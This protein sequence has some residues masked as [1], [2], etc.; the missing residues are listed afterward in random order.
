MFGRPSTCCL[1]VC[2]QKGDAKDE[3]RLR[4]EFLQ[5]RDAWHVGEV[6][7][8]AGNT[9]AHVLKVSVGTSLHSSLARA[10][11]VSCL[12][13]MNHQVI[14]AQRS[15]WT[16]VAR[17]YKDLFCR[18]G[19]ASAASLLLLQR[20]LSARIS[21]FLALLTRYVMVI[22]SC[23]ETRFCPIDVTVSVPCHTSRTATKSPALLTNPCS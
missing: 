18:V 14:E 10:A 8:L 16:D 15:Q 5:C 22:A 21:W 17:Q 11:L 4:A 13:P 1:H 3:A 7:G 12:G 6:S 2:L 19:T 20:W 9:A 23:L